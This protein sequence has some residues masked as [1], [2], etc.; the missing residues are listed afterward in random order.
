VTFD[1]AHHDGQLA[2]L[3]PWTRVLLAAMHPTEPGRRDRP[4][5][6]FRREPMVRISQAERAS[7]RVEGAAL[8]AWRDAAGMSRTPLARR[9]GVHNETVKR[10]ERGDFAIPAVARRVLAEMGWPSVPPG[11][12]TDQSGVNPA[13]MS[14]TGGSSRG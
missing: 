1:R 3:E 9:C 14:G 11:G 13:A 2:G 8:R 4:G 5:S 10:W 12:E 7:R 6:L